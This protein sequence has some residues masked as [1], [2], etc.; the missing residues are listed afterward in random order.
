MKLL[1]FFKEYRRRQAKFNKNYSKLHL[2][3]AN[4]D[5]ELYDVYVDESQKSVMFISRMDKTQIWSY[6][7]ESLRTRLVTITTEDGM[8]AGR[9]FRAIQEAYDLIT[10]LKIDAKL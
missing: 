7:T 3:Q 8:P 1:A 9:S 2:H 10:Q 4:L 5:G 6:K